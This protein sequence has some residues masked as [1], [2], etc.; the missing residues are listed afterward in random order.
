MRIFTKNYFRMSS[1]DQ[2]KAIDAILHD[3][4]CAH[5][6]TDEYHKNAARYRRRLVKRAIEHGVYEEGQ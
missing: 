2:A 5:F 6:V 4:D 3:I 1:S